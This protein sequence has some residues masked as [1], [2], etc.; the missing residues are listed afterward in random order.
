MKQI[1]QNLKTGKTELVEVP[2]PGAKSGHIVILTRASLISA[3][4]ERMLLEFGKANLLDKARQQPEKVKQALEKIKT[5]GLMPTID[6]V[7]NKLD[8]PIPL[9]YSNVGTIVREG[10]SEGGSRFQEGDRVVSNGP[11]AEVVCVPRNLCAKIPDG[12]SDEDAA[13]TVVGAIGLQGI[14]L[15]QPTLGESFAVI[16]LGLIGQIAVQILVANGCRV[17][18][19]DI[20]SAR[21]ELAKQFGAE[22]VAISKG[23]D[24]IE[25]AMSFSH[26]NGIDGVIITAA[27]KSNE[28]IHQAAQM[29]RKRGR[30]VLVGV[31]GLELSRA[32]FYE[33][34]LSFQVSCSY[35]PGRYDPEYE[36]KGH[37]YPLGYV[38]WT[39]QRNFEAVLDL[40]ATGKLDVKPLITHRFPFEEAT[41]AYD[42]IS[43][44]REPYLGIILKYKAESEG[45]ERAREGESIR[46]TLSKKTISIKES[47]PAHLTTSLPHCSVGLIGAGNHSLSTL[48]PALSR[49]TAKLATVVD[50][51]PVAAAHASRKFGFEQSTTDIEEIFRDPDINTVFITTRH[52]THAELVIKALKAGKHV[53]VEKPLCISSDE[54]SE[55]VSVRDSE[56]EKTANEVSTSPPPSL[57]TSPILML[58]YNRRFAP[59]IMKIKELL[60]PIKEPKSMI[61]TV[62][63]GMIPSDHWTQD[64]VVGGGRIIGEVC[65]FIDLL[66]FLAGSE[67][68][69]SEIVR[70]ENKT[71]DTVT[72]QLGFRDGSIGTIH[73]FA[74]GSKRFPKERLEIFAG[75]KVLQLDNFKT[76]KGYGCKGFSRMKLWRQDK[77]HAAEMRAFVDAVR[78]GKPSPIPFEEIVEVMR[79]TLELSER[80][81]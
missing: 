20:D 55:I 64:P 14:R 22:T 56:I 35:G 72:I 61:M 4:T 50:I 63:A 33:K 80:G 62:N 16:G 71:G 7:R 52:N 28:P 21:C 43:E 19:I 8:Q 5:D 66:R 47:P 40:M 11:H 24:P 44:N 60:N 41:K 68:G 34:E 23:E 77:G 81:R 27:T 58:G 13:F 42:L 54:L 53:F 31:T 38:R 6:A 79:I 70:L 46:G 1:L 39:E 29:C 78:D 25:S 10:D 17:L 57:P 75:Q 9:G 15:A 18:G 26:G 51:N 2:V 48:L 3:G 74:N 73:Y 30:I 76:L 49:T 65:H 37:D 59:H 12:V 69:S 67:I 45:S 36:E 32:D